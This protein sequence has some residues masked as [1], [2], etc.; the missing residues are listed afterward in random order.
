M[1]IRLVSTMD[2]INCSTSCLSE[3]PVA[4]S[5]PSVAA[6]DCCRE[7]PQFGIMAIQP[8]YANDLPLATDE[9]RVAALRGFAVAC[10]VYP[11]SQPPRSHTWSHGV[12]SF[13]FWTNR[14]RLTSAFWI[15]CQQVK[16]SIAYHF[17]LYGSTGVD[18]EGC[19]SGSPDIPCRRSYLVDYKL[20]NR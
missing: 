6:S 15:L 2:R 4:E 9:Q 16:P 20:S 3:L 10:F 7:G 12:W 17:R 11:I 8:V 18:F 1:V 13:W 5:L 14:Q 19:C